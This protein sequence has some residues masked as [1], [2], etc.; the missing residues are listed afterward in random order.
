M[1]SALFVLVSAATLS[2]TARADAAPVTMPAV[3]GFGEFAYGYAANDDHW[4]Y[5]TD[6]INHAFALDAAAIANL[7]LSN[8]FNFEAEGRIYRVSN[9]ADGNLSS[10]LAAYGHLFKR[11][12]DGAIGGF[13]G[14]GSLSGAT[15]QSA[16]GEAVAYWGKIDL[17]A[18]AGYVG[19]RTDHFDP[20]G[21]FARGAARLFLTPNTR[22]QADVQWSS[23]H[24]DISEGFGYT[25]LTVIGTAEHRFD[26][27]PLSLFG[28]AR[29]DR[30]DSDFG[31]PGDEFTVSVG[32]RAYFGGT[33]QDN[34]RHGAPFDLIPIRLADVT[35]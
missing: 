27:A 21:W 28:S 29:W 34:D 16:G 7:P 26:A 35:R 3:M 32:L 24:A 1:R 17:L 2:L 19:L 18:Q 6:R 31:D 10:L 25:A 8:Q 33:L 11:T 4:L 22:L 30:I 12:D 14:I 20:D 23:V 15:L 13:G 9:S 5:D